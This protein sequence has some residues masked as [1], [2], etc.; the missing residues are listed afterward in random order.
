MSGVKEL[1]I[2]RK[3]GGATEAFR[4]KNGLTGMRFGRLTV[5]GF[6]HYGPRSRQI[7]N[8]VCECGNEKAVRAD[9][10]LSGAT[11]S[12]RCLHREIKTT[13]GHYANDE[14][15]PTYNSWFSMISRCCR[16]THKFYH[17]YGG[18]GVVVCERWKTFA[19]FL[20]DDG[21]YE[22]TNC[23]WATHLEQQNNRRDNRVLA[24]R[25]KRLTVKQWARRIG[26]SDRTLLDR[27]KLGW[28]VTQTLSLPPRTQ[29]F[30]TAATVRRIRA[31]LAAGVKRAEIAERCGCTKGTISSVATGRTWSW[32]TG[33]VNGNARRKVA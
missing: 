5:T 30:I 9:A 21:N 24:W 26:I 6:S 20:A 13:H 31:M 12:C 14:P 16:K 23:R 32:V 8:C 11:Q 10:L 33:T 25:G 17:L 3:E 1:V 7:W 29:V 2:D 15:S 28:T 18:A 22:P 19:G 27:L 4:G